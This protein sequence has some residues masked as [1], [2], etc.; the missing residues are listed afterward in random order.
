MYCQENGKK[1]GWTLLENDIEVPN[2]PNIPIGYV[3]QIWDHPEDAF[4]N[5]VQPP[6]FP[7]VYLKRDVIGAIMTLL[8]G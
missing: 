6:F 4:P 3:G 5:R 8:V 7:Y 2:L 1:G